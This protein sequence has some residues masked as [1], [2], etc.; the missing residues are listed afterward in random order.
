MIY[1]C[2]GKAV[3]PYVITNNLWDVQGVRQFRFI[4]E[5]VTK[6]TLWLNGDR[7]KM[8]VSDIL[9]RI[10]PYLGNQAEI[11]V[12]YVE[13]IPVLNSGKRKYI[14]NRCETYKGR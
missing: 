7:D 13:E 3:T 9:E 6:Y 8:N 12:E 5:D 1:D 11:N 14:E 10:R 2:Q 4:Q